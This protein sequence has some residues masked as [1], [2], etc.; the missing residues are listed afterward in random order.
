VNITVGSYLGQ[1]TSG[2]RFAPDVT[3]LDQPLSYASVHPFRPSAVSSSRHH[4]TGFGIESTSP[5]IHSSLRRTGNTHYVFDK[6][7]PVWIFLFYTLP[8]QLYLHFLFRLPAFYFTRVAHIF[9]EAE[10]TM[11]EIEQMAN[12]HGTYQHF[13]GSGS[14]YY[15]DTQDPNSAPAKLTQLRVTWSAFIDSL[16]EEWKTL[17]IVS[18]LLLSCVCRIET[19]CKSVEIS[20]W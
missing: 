1:T 7:E 5:A 20:A 4:T 15:G 13:L 18:A 12:D 17:N 16:L 10:M 6:L 11:S 3:Y 19:N 8:R 2:A 14:G 9:E